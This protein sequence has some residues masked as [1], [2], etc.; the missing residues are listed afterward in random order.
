MIQYQYFLSSLTFLSNTPLPHH[1][2]LLN[3]HPPS[4]H[5]QNSTTSS[6]TN[7]THYS[8]TTSSSITHQLTLFFY[9]ILLNNTTIVL[10]NLYTFQNRIEKVHLLR[11]VPNSLLISS[12]IG[13]ILFSYKRMASPPPEIQNFSHLFP[14]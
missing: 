6:Q 11:I 1:L 14:L 2:S 13:T 12:R 3:S 7:T 4:A 9:Y 10:F 5:T 8:N